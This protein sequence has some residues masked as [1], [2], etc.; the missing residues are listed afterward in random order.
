SDGEKSSDNEGSS[1]DEEEPDDSASDSLSTEVASD[2][3]KSSDNEGSSDDE[4][5]LDD[6]GGDKYDG[7][8]GNITASSNVKLYRWS[9]EEPKENG[10]ISEGSMY[11]ALTKG[12]LEKTANSTMYYPVVFPAFAKSRQQDEPHFVYYVTDQ[13]VWNAAAIREVSFHMLGDADDE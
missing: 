10:E 6:D 12:S 4:E 2:G 5:E 9:N 3:E 13:P 11:S 8:Y 7:T 1:D